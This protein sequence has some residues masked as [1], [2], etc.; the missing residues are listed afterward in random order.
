M[1]LAIAISA[2]DVA[3][4]EVRQLAAPMGLAISFV[5]SPGYDPY[6]AVLYTANLN[7]PVETLATVV[8]AN[9]DGSYK[10]SASTLH[11]SL[12]ELVASPPSAIPTDTPTMTATES[13]SA[14]S[15]QTET[16]TGVSIDVPTITTSPIATAVYQ[17]YLPVVVTG[18]IAGW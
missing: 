12:F 9:G 10:A 6:S 13:P 2:S 3:G 7:G 8:V 5:P 15:T 4:N 17:V 1:V 16:S 14:T 18:T 11:L